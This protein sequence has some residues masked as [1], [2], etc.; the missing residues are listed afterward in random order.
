M[1]QPMLLAAMMLLWMSTIPIVAQQNTP[2]PITAP[3]ASAGTDTTAT[4][5]PTIPETSE[6]PE[7]P[8]PAPS[9]PPASLNPDISLIGNALGSLANHEINPN[10]PNKTINLNETEV[11]IG[12]KIYPG[13]SGLAV[14]TVG[15]TRDDRAGVEESYISVEQLI[16]AAPIGARL[17]IARLPFGKVN[18][19]H[20]HSLPF[21]DTPSVLNNLLGDF[22]GNGFEFVGLIPTHSN[23]FLQANLGRWNSVGEPGYSNP[24]AGATGP[25]FN[26]GQPLTLGRLWAST[27]IGED[28]EVEL[29]ASGAF[30]NADPLTLAPGQTN[31]RLNIFGL[32]T[33]WR[34]YLPDERR[35]LVSAEALQRNDANVK[36]SG[37]YVLGTFRPGH[38]YEFGTRYDW[39]EFAADNTHHESYASL[40]A[41]RFLSEQT[42]M[43]LQVKHGTDRLDRGVN[44]LIAQVVWGFGPHTHPL[45]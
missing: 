23:I 32:D 27:A 17:G 21:A 33:T 38:F 41:T 18:P 34:T 43:R 45:Q 4:E 22:R 39:S 6:N 9:A 2:T 42:F 10:E 1:K 35:I 8:A 5:S 20:P 31:P 30:G 13:V 26:G 14:F 11:V 16:S 7:A 40:F 25:D 12:S 37:Y 28:N 15:G 29:G 19:L 44:E 36:T 3:M 24:L